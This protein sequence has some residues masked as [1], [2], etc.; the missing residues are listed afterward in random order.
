MLESDYLKDSAHLVQKL[1][2]ISTLKPFD[3]KDLHGAL[4]LS[5]IR[6]YNPGELILEE[7]SFDNWIY[8]LISGKVRVVKGGKDLCLLERTGDVFGEMGVIDGSARSASIYAIDETVCLVTDASYLDRLSGRDKL[9]FG[10]V[11]FR[12]FSEILANRLRST[13]QDLISAKEEIARLRSE[14]KNF[15]GRC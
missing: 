14:D 8:F 6:K 7:G 12:V 10:Y 5:K 1:K 11:L 15:G 13:T 3:D 4:K 2:Q 9:A